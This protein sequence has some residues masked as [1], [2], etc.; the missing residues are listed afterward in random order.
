MNALLFKIVWTVT[1]FSP[2][3]PYAS[4]FIDA[5]SFYT[6]TECRAAGAKLLPRTTEWGRAKMG[7]SWDAKVYVTYHCA[8]LLG[9]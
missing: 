8:S 7:V 9:E 4:S 1:V 5:Q 6:E 2:N 3:A